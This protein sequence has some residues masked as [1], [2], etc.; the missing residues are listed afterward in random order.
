V[1]KNEEVPMKEIKVE[2]PVEIA[3]GTYSNTVRI[4]H[5]PFEF[6]IDF[7]R[8]L[9]EQPELIKIVERIVMSPQHTKAFHQALEENV[10]RYESQF[11]AITTP[12]RI[13]TA[14]GPEFVQ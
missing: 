4:S 1:K 7:G 6:V 14:K 13:P 5:T 11:G 2:V 10:R 9:P 8:T 3:N 12:A